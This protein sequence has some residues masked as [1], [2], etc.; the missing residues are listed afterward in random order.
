MAY[1]DSRFC[2]NLDKVIFDGVGDYDIPEIYPEEYV[3]VE[4]IPFHEANTTTQ[5]RGKGVHFF[6]DDYVFDRVW[7]QLDKN[8]ERLSAFDAVLAPDWSMYTDWPIAMC[9]W[10]HYRKHFVAAYLQRVVGT[11]VYPTICWGDNTTLN[12]CFD[13]EPV[14]GCVAVSSVGTQRTDYEKRYFMYGYDAM[15]ERLQPKTIMFYGYIPKECRGNVVQIGSYRGR[16]IQ[17]EDD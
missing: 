9:I 13:G 15:L 8:V 10:N 3:D 5:K 17:K 12:W 2:N 6:L 4:W 11:R 7:N 1:R 14:G 16:L